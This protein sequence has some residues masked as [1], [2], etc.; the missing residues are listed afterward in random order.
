[1]MIKKRFTDTLNLVIIV[2]IYRNEQCP[3]NNY[4]MQNENHLVR[5]RDLLYEVD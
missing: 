2:L 4:R 3:L 5:F 1:M